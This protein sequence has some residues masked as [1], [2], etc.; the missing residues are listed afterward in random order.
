MIGTQHQPPENDPLCLFTVSWSRPTA[1]RHPVRAALRIHT[2]I[3]KPKPFHRSPVDQV[4]L[5]NL[6]GILW[7]NVSV[8]DRLWV[9]HNRRAVLAL[10][11]AAGLVD[12]DGASQARGLRKLLQLRVQFA[13]AVR[14]TRWPRSTFGTSVMANKDV[15]LE[16]WQKCTSIS[17]L[18]GHRSQP[19]AHIPQIAMI[20]GFPHFT[21]LDPVASERMI[22]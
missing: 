20:A 2:L 12:S 5:H 22:A 8:P 19:F 18:Q 3:R 13:L 16:N 6:L 10:V 1:H 9:N 14:G 17:R 4:L 7:L 11:K 21:A 15:M